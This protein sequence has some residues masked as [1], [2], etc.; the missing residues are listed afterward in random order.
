MERGRAA[1]WRG[2][3]FT[4][5]RRRG[6]GW[7]KQQRHQRSIRETEIQLEPHTRGTTTAVLHS[8]LEM[9]TAAPLFFQKYFEEYL[10]DLFHGLFLRF[11]PIPPLVYLL[12]NSHRIFHQFLFTIYWLLTTFLTAFLTTFLIN[13]PPIFVTNFF[14]WFLYLGMQWLYWKVALKYLGLFGILKLLYLI[15]FI[16]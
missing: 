6:W 3:S 4:A 14:Q 12:I 2:G 7:V 8:V 15:R 5:G 16:D 1:P 11:S 9:I 10:T 13:F